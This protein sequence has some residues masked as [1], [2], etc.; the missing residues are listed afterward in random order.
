M[1]IL[2]SRPLLRYY[3]VEK[4]VTIQTDAGQSG[5]GSC[6][7]Q[8]GRHVANASRAMTDCEKNYAHIE[9]DMLAISCACEE[10]NRYLFG[11]IVEVHTDHRPLE[12]IFKKPIGSASPRLQR[13]LHKTQRC[14]LREQYLPGR[15]MFVADTLSRAYHPITRGDHDISL[16]SIKECTTKL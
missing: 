2:S 12:I 11:K 6:L 15:Y 3:G 16:S 1:E 10:F 7:L 8:E 9:K 4:P 5:H 13:M 14:D